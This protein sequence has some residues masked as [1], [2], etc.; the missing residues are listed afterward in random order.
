ME[1]DL[2]QRVVLDDP[3]AR[4]ILLPR[5]RF[6]PG[7]KRLQATKDGRV[8]AWQLQPFPCVFRWKSKA[9]RIGKTLHL[10]VEPGAATGLL[11]LLDHARKHRGEMGYVGDR[12]VDLPLVERPA[13]PIGEARA[14]VEAV[15]EQA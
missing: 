5:L 2:V 14:L 11:E 8:A 1:D 15:P 13:A 6:A 4:Q 9:R 7:G 10:L 12:V 3:A